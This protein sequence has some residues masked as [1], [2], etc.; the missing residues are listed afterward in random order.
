MSNMADNKAG[1][2]KVLRYTPAG[3]AKWLWHK[4]RGR[5]VVV[6]GQCD[7]CGRCCLHLNLSYGDRWIRKEKDFRA[8]LKDYPDYDRFELIGKTDGGLLIFKCSMITE[9]GKCGD[10]ENRPDICREYPD[11]DL[12]YSGGELLDHCGYS[13]KVVPSFKR[14]MQAAQKTSRNGNGHIES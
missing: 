11:P 6:A 12:L 8:M 3:L 10:H 9:D 1:I 14:V 2:L 5:E 7:M 13:F 4:A